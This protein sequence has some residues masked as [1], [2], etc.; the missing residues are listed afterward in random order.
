MWGPN[1]DWLPDQDHGSNIML[2]LQNMLLFANG[3]KIELLP[4]W[5]KEWDVSFKLHAPRQT[6]V[7]GKVSNGRL[8]EL[9]V[10]PASRRKDVVVR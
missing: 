2:T 9:R 6:V 3:D 7:E 10:T 8:T 5:P 4:A 1:Y